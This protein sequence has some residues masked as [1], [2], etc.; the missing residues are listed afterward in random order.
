MTNFDAGEPADIEHLRVGLKPDAIPVRAKQRRYPTPKREF[1]TRY[2]R[3]LTKLGF[4]KK[5]IAPEWVSAPLIVP[6][7]PPAMYRLTLDYRPVNSATIPTFWPMPNIEA[8][9]SDVRGSTAFAGIDFCSGY[10]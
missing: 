1:T 2:V 4:V 3:E 7:R 9:I 5:T 10:W 8:E 6:K